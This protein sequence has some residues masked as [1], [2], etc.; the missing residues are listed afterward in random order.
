MFSKELLAILP[1]L[2]LIAFAVIHRPR[3]YSHFWRDISDSFETQ[4]GPPRYTYNNFTIYRPTTFWRWYVDDDFIG[5][6]AE[7]DMEVGSDGFWL[8]NETPNSMKVAHQLF[9]PWTHIALH[10]QK[11]DRTHFW[12]MSASPTE[13]AVPHDIAEVLLK[14]AK[15]SV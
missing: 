9:I 8:R 10:E 4:Q 12:I 5:E 14:N 15:G 6:Y 7:F 2:V 1:I 13:I 11:R 3:S